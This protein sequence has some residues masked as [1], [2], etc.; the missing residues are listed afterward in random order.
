MIRINLLTVE[1]TR[2]KVRK[3]AAI[4]PAAQRVTVGAC[5]VLV[6]TLAGI[7]GWFWSLRQQSQAL[8]R[9]IARAEADTRNLR[10]VLAQV[11]KFETR[12]AQLQQR[13]TLI[14]QLRKGQS[15]PVRVLDQISRSVPDRLWL[16]DLKQVGS[17]FTLDGFATSMTAL[18]D[19]VAAVESTKW[20]RKPVEI[21]DS[22]VTSDAKKG[23]LVRFVVK[24]SYFD[25]DAPPPP[26]P[27]KGAPKK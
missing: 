25:P 22:Q 5:I 10:S 14:E 15:A 17:D 7:G 4:M 12:K 8:E 3:P 19:F 21:I 6:A 18:T 9:D 24:A 2:T 16:A 11:Q 13:V 1:R 27:V 23:D 26:A 20:F